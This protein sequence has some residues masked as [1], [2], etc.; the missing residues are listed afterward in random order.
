MRKTL[1]LT[2]VLL[3]SAV[4][5]QAQDAGKT[6]GKT[7]DLDTIEGCLQRSEGQYSLTDNT[8]T[9]HH[10]TGGASKLNPHVGHEVEITGKPGV[11]TLDTTPQGGAS[12][13]VEQPIFEVKSVK[14]IAD[15]C[16]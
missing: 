1:V 6:G 14:H 16:K 4:W 5:L 7:S 2:L 3:A 12:S 9:I 13:A 15:T 8:G 10:L 11:R